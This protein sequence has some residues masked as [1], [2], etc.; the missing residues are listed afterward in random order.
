MSGIVSCALHVLIYLLLTRRGKY[1]DY[2]H[3]TN[4]ETEVVRYKDLA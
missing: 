3:F 1:C 4:G 2:S